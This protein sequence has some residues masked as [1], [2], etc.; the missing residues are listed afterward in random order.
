MLKHEAAAYL[1]G[2]TSEDSSNTADPTNVHVISGEV[3]GTSE[4]GKVLVSIDGMMFSE[5]DDQYVEVDALGG[6]EDGDVAT[7]MLTGESGHGMTPFALGTAGTVDR[8]KA[9][10]VNAANNAQAAQATADAAQAVAEATNQH[11]FSDENGIHVTEETQ[12]DWNTNHTGANVLIN[13]VGQL[14]RDGLN[15]LLTLTTENG[16]RSLAIW[17]GLGNA[18]EHALALFS[19]SETHLGLGDGIASVFLANDKFRI[20]GVT[21][22]RDW[23]VSGLSGTVREA[24][25]NILSEMIWD[26]PKQSE[27]WDASTDYSFVSRAAVNTYSEI[28]VNP[29]GGGGNTAALNLSATVYDWKGTSPITAEDTYPEEEYFDEDNEFDPYVGPTDSNAARIELY[30]D[31]HGSYVRVMADNLNIFGDLNIV[32]NLAGNVNSAFAISTVQLLEGDV[33]IA[34]GSA[35]ATRTVSQFYDGGWYPLGIVGWA[36]NKT[37]V[38]M[39]RCRITVANEDNCT[40]EFVARNTGTA[41]QIPNLN[42]RVLWVRTGGVI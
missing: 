24:F 20:R 41:T 33:S 8:V 21:K 40:V 9:T 27:S 42:V 35:T 15:N 16:A 31:N 6:L 5:D 28:P 2:L 17:D 25:G 29:T 23:S 7:I 30:A 34:A 22:D 37:E 13:S 19:A 39:P 1:A 36:C 10:A 38:L 11:F 18:A 4:D 3:S 14:F 12:E 32:D 26:G